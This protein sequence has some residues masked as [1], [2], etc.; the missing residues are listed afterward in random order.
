MHPYTHILTYSHTHTP[1]HSHTHPLTHTLI[2]SHSHTHTPMH[3]PRCSFPLHLGYH[4]PMTTPI[5]PAYHTL[6]LLHRAD[7]APCELE[8]SGPQICGASSW[9]LHFQLCHGGGTVGRCCAQY[10]ERQPCLHH[11]RAHERRKCGAVRAEEV[12]SGKSQ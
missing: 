3:S 9:Y 8:G 6:P 11:Q 2:H 1:M 12:W 5:A 4:S 7:D 10:G